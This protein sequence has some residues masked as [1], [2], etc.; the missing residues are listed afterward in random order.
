MTSRS[1]AS[2]SGV[3][4]TRPLGSVRLEVTENL[5]S[6]WTARLQVRGAVAPDLRRA[7]LAG[8]QLIAEGSEPG[9]ELRLVDGRRVGLTAEEL[10]RL[11][12]ARATV[13]QFGHV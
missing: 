2:L 6:P 8:L 1:A 4:K 10:S 12:G 7:V 5:P 11:Q 9:A 13:A 3:V